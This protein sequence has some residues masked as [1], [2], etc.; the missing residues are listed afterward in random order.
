MEKRDLYTKDRKHTGRTVCKG[1]T[2]PEGC[3]IQV[4][5]IFMENTEGKYL[6]QKRVPEKN[7]CYAFTSGHPKAGESSFQGI[8]TE[9]REELGIE[10]EPGRVEHLLAGRDD[11]KH[12]FWDLYYTHIDI[13]DLSM[14]KLQKEEVESVKWCNETEI[15]EMMHAGTFFPVHYKEFRMMKEL[16]KDKVK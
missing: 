7:G 16:R 13:D 2:V 4:V 14:L 11:Q 9:V 8:L 10:L 12:C 3:F 5:V 6:I 1:E 15:D